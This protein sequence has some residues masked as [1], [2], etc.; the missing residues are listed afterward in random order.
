MS[1]STV[2]YTSIS[3]DY[4]EPSD[5]GSPGVV[6][7]GYDRL[8]MHPVDPYV[9]AALQ[10]PEQAS[11]S[12]DYVPGPKHPPSPN[13]VPGP[14]EPE[15]APLSLDN[16]PEP[17]Y[18]EYLEA[19]EDDDEEKEE[20]PA[21]VDSFVVPVDDH[22]P[23]AEDTEA[24]ETYESAP[25]PIPS[26]RRRTARM[27][28]RPQTP[29]LAATEALI[30][31]S[32]RD[33]VESYIT[34]HPPS[35][36]DTITTLL[37]PSTTHRD[38]LPEADMPLQ[39]RARFTAP[40][41]RFEVRESSLVATARQAGHTL[42]HTVDY[43][44]IDTLDA[45]IRASESRAMTAVGVVNERVTDLASTQR[46]ETHKLQVCCEDA[47]DDRALLGAQVSILRRERRYFRSMAS[48]YERER[49]RTKDED[50]LTTHIQHEHDRFKDLVRVADAGPHDGP[51]DVGSS[52]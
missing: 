47:Q 37:L 31:V 27:S 11:P 26:P 34:I 22:V 25:T 14:K 38:D 30:A 15:Q 8:P 41:S 45:S 2:T 13:Y 17:E 43:G 39:K 29:M 6:V 32:S 44:F 33:S 20:H 23:S 7:Y 10:A 35:I 21:P 50:R 9:E 40:T 16:V 28:V 5:V 52:C 4:E 18:P 19:S 12:L 42:A 49:K 24:F 46:H 36:R 1:S 51:E 3:S 48:S